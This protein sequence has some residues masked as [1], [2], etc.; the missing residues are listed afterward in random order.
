MNSIL[1][2]I[3]ENCLQRMDQGETL[4]S[5]LA[6]Y[7]RL[8]GELRPLLEAAV[9]AR[10]T[11]RESLPVGVLSRQRS[12][13]LA[14]AADLRQGKNPALVLG[15]F[16][17]PVLMVLSVIVLL[18]IGTNN[19]LTASAHSL[20][21]DTLYPLKR[22]VESTQLQ[23]VSDP[24]KKLELEHTFSQ[25][26]VDETKSLISEERAEEVEF[27][28]VVL[29]Q[30]DG[31]WLV[32][33]IPV[34]VNSQTEIEKGIK[35]GD[36]IEV[37][38]S[39]NSAGDVVAISLRLDQDHGS[40]ATLP[41]ESPTQPASPEDGHPEDTSIPTVLPEEDHPEV[42]PTQPAFPEGDHPES[43]P[44]QISS[45]ENDH[46]EGSLTQ[47]PFPEGDHPESSSTQSPTPDGSD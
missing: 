35:V 7:P 28:G 8:A 40:D 20:P 38:G 19:L 14:L 15:R 41:E 6:H 27:T 16:W 36:V 25:R 18:V 13:G 34:V 5:V 39:T 33:G 10:S 9:L 22:S 2:D 3:L 12:R 30:S 17:R 43:T 47:T 21:G 26:R 11:S 31:E 24:V 1:P 23:L 29:S 46:S 45:P 32:S 4:D 42:S 44:T 37:K